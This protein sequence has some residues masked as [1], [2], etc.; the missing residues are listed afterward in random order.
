MYRFHTET[1]VLVLQLLQGLFYCFPAISLLVRTGGGPAGRPGAG[2]NK[3]KANSAQLGWAGA[4]AELGNKEIYHM[5]SKVH[6]GWALKIAWMVRWGEVCNHIHT[7]LLKNRYSTAQNGFKNY[8]AW[9]QFLPAGNFTPT[10]IQSKPWGLET[11]FCFDYTCYIKGVLKKFPLVNGVFLPSS[12][13]A[14]ALLGAE[15]A[16]FSVNPAPHSPSPTQVYCAAYMS[17]IVTKLQS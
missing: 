8:I 2:G 4:W 16:L 12:D 10:A 3:I 1:T 6:L 17:P 5:K 11:F 7:S 14:E 15:L 13:Q 9:S